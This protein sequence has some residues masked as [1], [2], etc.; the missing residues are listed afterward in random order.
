LFRAITPKKFLAVRRTAISDSLK[1]LPFAAEPKQFSASPSILSAWR[2]QAYGTRSPHRCVGITFGSVPFGPLVVVTLLAVIL[3][4]LIGEDM[5][6]E[7]SDSHYTL[8]NSKSRKANSW[9]RTVRQKILTI[10]HPFSDE[11]YVP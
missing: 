8:G 9:R 2:L 6:G 3:R 4:R 11:R 5:R 1:S 7:R 10:L